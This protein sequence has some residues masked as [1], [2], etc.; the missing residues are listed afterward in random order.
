MVLVVLLVCKI[1]VG[2]FFFCDFKILFEEKENFS[3]FKIMYDLNV[4]EN[5]LIYRIERKFC[6]I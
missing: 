2:G 3:V 1:I 6:M 5:F 4:R